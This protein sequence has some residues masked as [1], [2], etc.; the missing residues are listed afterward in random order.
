M[1]MENT[2]KNVQAP[3]CSSHSWLGRL[4]PNVRPSL[5]EHE[6]LRV[7]TGLAIV[8]PIGIYAHSDHHSTKKDKK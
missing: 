3:L 2:K 4:C 7:F 1:K 8:V 5:A 6:P